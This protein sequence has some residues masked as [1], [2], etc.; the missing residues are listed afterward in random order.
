MPR[1]HLAALLAAIVFGLIACALQG[2]THS[3]YEP[4]PPQQ[5]RKERG[6]VVPHDSFPRDCSLCHEG[7]TWHRIRDDFT[8]DHEKETGVA[9]QGAHAAAE[10]L[11]CHND[12]GPVEVFAQRGCAGCHEDVHRTKL[13]SNCVDCHSQSN[14]SPNEQVAKH[15]RTRFPLVGAHT[16]VSCFRCHPGS[17][18]GNFDRASTACVDCHADRIAFATSP[19]HVALGYTSNCDRCHIPTTWSGAGFNHSTFPLTGAHASQACSACHTGGVFAGTPTACVACHQADYNGAN[20]PPHA[21]S[22]LPTTCQQCHNT[23]AWS[24]ANFTHTGIV[25]GCVACHQ[26]DYTGATNPNHVALNISTQCQTCH[27]ST[28]TWDGATFDHVGITRGC[29]NCHQ[30]DYNS[31]TSP[32]H[33]GQGYPTTCRT[34]HTTTSWN[35]N[36]NHNPLFPIANGRHHVSCIQCHTNTSNP[37][38]FTCVTCHQQGNTNDEHDRVSGYAY[39]S[40]ACYACHPDGND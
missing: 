18:V 19:D 22:N 25:N 14:W 32:N 27:M 36:F 37:A 33:A 28:R 11:R 21:A 35:S 3:A 30:S 13:G 16:A 15:A 23:S 5:W 26:N 9:L 31:A 4:V 2:T 29:I 39:N 7:S 1:A 12:R 24:R 17:D 38:Q 40:N 8:F 6:P 10:C 20:D 34:C